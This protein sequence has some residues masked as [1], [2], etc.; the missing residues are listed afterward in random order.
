MGSTLIIPG[1]VGVAT[2]PSAPLAPASTTGGGLAILEYATSGEVAFFS[3][4]PGGKVAVYASSV[5]DSATTLGSGDLVR[6]GE[7]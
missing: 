4:V 5:N 6:E 3:I 2:S 7:A 1:E